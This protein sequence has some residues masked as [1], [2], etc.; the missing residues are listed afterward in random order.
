MAF[1]RGIAGTLAGAIA[2]RTIQGARL[3]MRPGA[4]QAKA[5]AQKTVDVSPSPVG[6]E[7]GA[8][9]EGVG[10]QTA[11]VVIPPAPL[12]ADFE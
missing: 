1:N 10:A 2:R 4:A 9:T 7:A 3:V 5:A 8:E 12:W 11:A 6:A